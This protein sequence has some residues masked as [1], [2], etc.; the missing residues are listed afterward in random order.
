VMMTS[1]NWSVKAIR[2]Q[3][4]RPHASTTCPAVDAVSSSAAATTMTVA[5]SA[6]M[7]ASGIH[8]SV[9]AVSASARRATG[10]GLLDVSV[11]PGDDTVQT[12]D[13]VFF[14]AQPVR[15]SRI[16]DE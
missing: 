13:E 2:S 9:H 8:R 5:S 16:D 7:N 6:K 4:P 3:K 14:L 10:P 12:I 11:K 1:A 15:L